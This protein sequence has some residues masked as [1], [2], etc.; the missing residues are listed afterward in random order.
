MLVD[1]Y[2]SEEDDRLRGRP[3]RTPA[4]IMATLLRIMLLW[5]PDRRF[6]FVGDAGYGTHE[7]S[8]FCH[9]HRERLTLVSKLHPEANLFE[10]PG[11]YGGNGRPRVKGAA[12]PK[13][14]RV[15]ARS[16][17]RTSFAIRIAPFWPATPAT[18]SISSSA[19]PINGLGSIPTAGRM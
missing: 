11:P 6:V 5:F 1:L 10:P 8:R 9:R 16:S 3:H 17:T 18:A 13:P 19:R 15:A 7:L 4:Q 12:L 2:R 14:G